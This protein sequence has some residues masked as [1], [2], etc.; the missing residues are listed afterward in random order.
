[1]LG[2]V[3]FFCLVVVNFNVSVILIPS[4]NKFRAY[5]TLESLNLYHDL[6]GLLI[7][8]ES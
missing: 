2:E 6:C 7:G 3:E 5:L 1:M 8:C 4:E